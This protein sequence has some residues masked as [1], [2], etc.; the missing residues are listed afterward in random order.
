MSG[1]V[2]DQN[3]AAEPKK[4]YSMEHWKQAVDEICKLPGS[5]IKGPGKDGGL[6]W[7]VT[8]RAIE[9]ASIRKWKKANRMIYPGHPGIWAVRGFHPDDPSHVAIV[10][11]EARPGFQLWTNLHLSNSDLEK[12]HW[13][14]L[15]D[16]NQNFEWAFIGNVSGAEE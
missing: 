14:N 11:I 3:T 9:L 1:N 16:L 8:Q 15:N 7:M 12:T 13:K 10:T 2:N 5:Q 6:W 4:P